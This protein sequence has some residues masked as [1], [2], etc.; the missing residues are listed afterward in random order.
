MVLI[1]LLYSIPCHRYGQ[2]NRPSRR[3]GDG[4]C[5]KDV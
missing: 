3:Q 1:K 2:L 5:G 4:W